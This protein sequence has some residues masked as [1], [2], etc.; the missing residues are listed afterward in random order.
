[1][2]YVIALHMDL[3]KTCWQQLDQI[4]LIFVAI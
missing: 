4:F 3:Y 2:S 1:M